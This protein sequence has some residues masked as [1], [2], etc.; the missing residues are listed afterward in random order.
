MILTLMTV[1]MVT[2]VLMTLILIIMTLCQHQSSPNHGKS[3]LG[4]TNIEDNLEESKYKIDFNNIN[5]NDM[6]DL[7]TTRI[8]SEV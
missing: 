1:L 6:K 8:S 4:A 2:V 7:F 3:S 5:N